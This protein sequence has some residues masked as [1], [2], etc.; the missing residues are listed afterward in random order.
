MIHRLF[1]S[2]FALLMSLA[3]YAADVELNPDHPQKYVVVKGD[4]LWDISG[5][6]LKYPWHWPEIWYV[7]PQVDNPHLIY[8]GDVLTLTYCDGKPCIKVDRGSRTVKLSPQVREI[9]LDKPIPTIPLDAI[10][11][12]LTRPLVVGE[13]TLKNSPYI[14]ASTDERLIAGG[15]DIIYARGLDDTMGKNYSVFRGGKPY[16]DVDTE[17]VLGYEA[18][19]TGDAELMRMGD[20]AKLDLVSANREVRAGDRLLVIEDENYG[21]NFLPKAYEADLDGKIISVFDGLS[22]VGQYQIVVLNKGSNVLLEPGHV[23]SIYQAGNM[24]KDEVLASEESYFGSMEEYK[25]RNASVT[26]P[27][28][29]AGIALVFKTFEKVSYAIVLK[30]TRAIHVG[31][32]VIATQ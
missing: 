22:Q 23:L 28:E 29:E 20:P 2:V 11:P 15:G 17:E 3:V 25:N 26:M 10:Y 13:E 24:I 31:D 12:F 4:T 8:P 14:V 32:K 16:I 9:M 18:I 27:D 21:A 30:A 1:V 7:N 6:F 19:Y 5:K